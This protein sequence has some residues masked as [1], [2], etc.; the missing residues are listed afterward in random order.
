[1]ALEPCPEC[2]GQKSTKATA[3]PHCGYVFKTLGYQL[4]HMFLWLILVCAIVQ[5]LVFIGF[6]LMTK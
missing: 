3:C 4:L 5:S 6:W 1:M 2:G